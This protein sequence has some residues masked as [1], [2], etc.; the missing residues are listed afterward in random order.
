MSRLTMRAGSTPTWDFAATN[1]DGTAKNLT[2]ATLVF[3]AIVPPIAISRTPTVTNAAGGIGYVRPDPGDT[4]AITQRSS[5]PYTLWI[6]E[7]GGDQ[8][9]LDSGTLE[10]TP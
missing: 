9:P 4:S 10:I 2:G 1:P 7:S 6:T 5:G 8:Y 3:T